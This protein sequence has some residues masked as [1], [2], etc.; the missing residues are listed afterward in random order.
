MYG[1]TEHVVWRF[2][3]KEGPG[4]GDGEGSGDTMADRRGGS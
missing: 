2:G 3:V 1:L 4:R